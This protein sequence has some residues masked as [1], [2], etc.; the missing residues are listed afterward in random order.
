MTFS[1]FHFQFSTFPITIFLL[2]FSIF[3]PFPFLPCQLFPDTSAK[4]SR[5][6]VLGGHSAPYPTCKAT[7]FKLTTIMTSVQVKGH[8]RS[9]KGNLNPRLVKY[10]FLTWMKVH[11]CPCKVHHVNECYKQSY[12]LAQ[13]HN[14]FQENQNDPMHLKSNSRSIHAS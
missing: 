5:S 10:L 4:I 3:T 1:Y 9:V 2:F 7:A 12:N 8:L 11:K 13:G 14:F 6:E